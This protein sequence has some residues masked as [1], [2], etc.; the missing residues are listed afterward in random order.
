MMNISLKKLTAEDLPLLQAVGRATYEPYY[1]HI[2]YEGGM[3]WYVHFCFNQEKLGAELISPNTEYWLAT[4]HTGQTIGFLKLVL[5]K[6]LP[7]GSEPNALYLEKVYLMPAFFGKG[8]GQYLIEFAVERARQLKRHAVWLMVMACGP[9]Q[10]YERQGFQLL[11][12]EQLDATLFH[13]MRLEYRGI[14]TMTRS[15]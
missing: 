15:I 6:A 5:Q 8:C 3:D 14:H 11:H 13:R 12:S 1:P 7:D 4:D 2:W 10:V 9:V